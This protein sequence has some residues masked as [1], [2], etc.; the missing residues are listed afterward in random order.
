MH[1]KY[2]GHISSDDASDKSVKSNDSNK[3]WKKLTENEV[4][5]I[6]EK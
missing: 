6:E 1:N 3:K 4:K 2:G 5:T